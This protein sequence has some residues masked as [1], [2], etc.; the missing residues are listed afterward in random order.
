VKLGD[1]VRALEKLLPKGLWE[2]FTLLNDV[3]IVAWEKPIIIGSGTTPYNPYTPQPYI[4]WT[5]VDHG[6]N[7]KFNSGT[8]NCDVQC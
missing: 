1:L 6:A 7:Y 8:F 2:N 3:Q 5:A 4:T